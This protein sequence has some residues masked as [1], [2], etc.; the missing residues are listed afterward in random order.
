ME[1]H[2]RLDET[3]WWLAG[4]LARSIGSEATKLMDAIEDSARYRPRLEAAPDYQKVAVALLDTISEMPE[5]AV[6]AFEGASVS[7]ELHV[8]LGAAYAIFSLFL[9]DWK[10]ARRICD[11]LLTDPKKSVRR[12]AEMSDHTAPPPDL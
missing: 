11:R 3:K 6:F 12:A 9:I 4:R 5:V 7:E 8:R 1:F 2:S 10:S